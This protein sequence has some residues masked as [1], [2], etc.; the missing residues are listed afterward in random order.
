MAAQASFDWLPNSETNLAGYKIYYGFSSGNYTSVIDIGLPDPVDGRIHGTIYDLTDGETYYF[1]ATAYDD[2]GNESDYSVEVVHTPSSA[3]TVTRTFGNTPDADLPGTLTDTFTNINDQILDGSETLSTWSWSSPS[4]HKVANTVLLKTDLSSIP[5]SATIVEARLY[6]YQ[7]AAHGASSYINTAHMITG[8]NPVIS[9]ASGYYAASGVA[10]NDVPAG[11]TYNDVPLGLADIGPAVDSVTLDNS[12]GYRTW[13]ITPMVKQWVADPASNLGL[14]LN[15]QDGMTSETGR[16]FAATENSNADIRPKLTVT[17]TMNNSPSPPVAANSSAYGPE[18]MAITGN[19]EVSNPDNLPL[20]YGITVQPAH[21]TATIDNASGQFTYTPLAD[22]HGQD[23]FSYTAANESGISNVATVALT[24]DPVNDRPVAQSA[25]FSTDEDTTVNGQLNASDIDGDTLNFVAVTGANNGS[26]SINLD[27]TFTYTPNANWNGT[28]AFSFKVGDGAAESDQQ[29][30]NITVQPVNDKPAALG[31]AFSTNEDTVLNAQLGASDADGDTLSYN[32]VTQPGKGTVSISSNGTF[33]YSPN[34]NLNGTDSFSFN[35]YDG[36]AYSNTATVSVSINPVNDAPTAESQSI[37][38]EAGTAVSGSLTATDVEGD[39]L[40]FTLASMSTQGDVILNPDGSFNYTARLEATG[41]D[42]FTFTVSDGASVSNLG[43]VSIS[44][45]ENT[46]SFRFELSEIQ[47]DSNWQTVHFGAAFVNPVVIAKAASFND[48]DTGGV[49]VRNVTSTG[50]ELKFQEWDSLDGQ[51]PNETITLMVIEAGSFTLDN[52]TMIEAGCFSATGASSFSPV[53]FEQAMTAAPVVMT[54]VNTFNEADAVT[55]RIRN[56]N[57]GGFEFMMR[58]QE[59]NDQIHGEET[60]CYIA[61]E[62][63]AGMLDNLRYEVAATGNQVTDK[64]HTVR[65]NTQFTETPLLLAAMQTTNGTDTAIL[66]IANNS[67]EDA[68]IFISEEQ[69]LDQ[70]TGHIE[71]RAGYI[72]IAAYDPAGDPD[73]DGLST[74]EEETTYHTHPGLMDTDK[75]GLDDGSEIGFW[76]EHGQSWNGDIDNDGLV[77]LL[78]SDSDGDGMIDGSEVSSGFDPADPNSVALFPPM[79]GGEVDVDSSWVHVDFSG[80][81]VKPVVIARLVSKNNNEPCVVRMDNVTSTGVDL[82]LQE[83]DYLDGGHPVEQVS[84]LVMEAGNYTLADG[85][86]IEAGSFNT[87]ATNNYYP[88]AFNQ[89]FAEVP[90]IVTSITTFNETD[91]VTS[92]MRKVDTT[93]FDCKLQEQEANAKKHL[94]ES[95]AYIAWEPAS[96]SQNGIRYE[97]S[98]STNTVTNAAKTLNYAAGFSNRPL[99]YTDMQTTDGGDTAALRTVNSSAA[100]LT[101]MVEEEQSKDSETSHTTEEAG[102][103]AIQAQ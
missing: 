3:D 21:G 100:S 30:V 82:R 36:A 61:W 16:T 72:A 64:L 74:L 91:T 53:T 79:E 51:H 34:A 60:A 27:G 97:V 95:V 76:L 6:L 54:A 56:I 47:V 88:F 81:Y 96:G 62:P 73:M 75:D 24:V 10:W 80:T 15:G 57:A 44:I 46:T 13:L 45:Q 99:L 4:P 59:A 29:Q 58:E 43:T 26:L 40:T 12:T 19:L 65:Y 37:S 5:P 18:D 84:Y 31:D 42:G 98:R 55:T 25:S 32:L 68:A 1:A 11:K 2:G 38:A 83:Y 35:A 89:E 86:R 41:M 50:F 77:N 70:E 8:H 78:D 52:G 94:N 69:S 48:G 101:V 93:G 92:R 23:A 85:T 33:T 39:N 90:V 20:Q 102:Y 7:T 103:I 71:E 87:N 17:Y 67:V 14:L 28:D 63:S 49:R 66:R 9:E 22:F